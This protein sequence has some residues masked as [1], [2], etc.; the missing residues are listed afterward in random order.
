MKKEK[1]PWQKWHLPGQDMD[2]K[3]ETIKEM[4]KANKKQMKHCNETRIHVY[5]RTH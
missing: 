1:L 5:K 3:Q 2:L 4:S